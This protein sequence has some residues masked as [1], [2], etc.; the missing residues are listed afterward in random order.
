MYYSSQVSPTP[1]AGA[2]TAGWLLFML[3]LKGQQQAT[4][5]R[6]WRAL[7]ALGAA[8][9]RD[10]VYLLP[11]R[12]EIQR[13][14]A[15]QTQ[16]VARTSGSAQLFEVESRDEQQEAQF[17]GLFDRT[18]DYQALI[19]EVH[20]L[21]VALKSAKAVAVS[22]RLVRLQREFEVIFA[23]D[24]FPAEAAN[25]ARRALEDASTAVRRVLSPG[26]PHPVRK[27]IE[28]VDPGRYQG[29]TWATRSR[30]WADR[31]G[32]AWLIRRF[33][34]PQARFLWLKDIRHCPKRAIGF[35]FDGAAFTHAGDKVT[36]EV[37]ME[38]FGLEAIAGLN[39]VA[40]LVHYLDVGGIPLPEAPGFESLLRAARD[41][42]GDDDA[43]LDEAARLFEL[44]HISCRR[45]DLE[46]S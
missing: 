21:G 22:T 2:K 45:P 5:M 3:T 19:R 8:V 11:N 29:R 30:P 24:F 12:I 39:R 20:K 10:G 15:M 44:M 42:F 17:R 4:R 26:E 35:D 34:D 40:A 37:L 43:L 33:I 18:S 16:E 13:S 38:S 23:Q 41:T 14:L 27:R 1:A 46:P 9:L 32:S 36:F 7:K 6:V 31:L 25:Q 28:R